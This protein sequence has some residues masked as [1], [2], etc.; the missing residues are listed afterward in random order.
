MNACWPQAPIIRYSLL[1]IFMRC[2][3]HSNVTRSMTEKGIDTVAVE[4]CP[5]D[6]RVCCHR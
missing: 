6:K 5:P 4:E 3:A 2:D 1:S